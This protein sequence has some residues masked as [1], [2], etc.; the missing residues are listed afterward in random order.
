VSTAV[1]LYIHP[2]TAIATVAALAY[3]GQLGLRGR[4]VRRD[5]AEMLR[6]HAR[7]TPYVYA[8]VLLS[9]VLGGL[10]VWWGRSDLDFADSGHFRVGCYVVAVLSVAMVLSR[11]IDRVPNGRVI[12]PLLGA[13]A[14]L[15][16]AFQVF[17]G[18]QIMPK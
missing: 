1:W 4:Q 7:V 14:V 13:L 12:H 6:R 11:L 10:S 5:G 9:W 18:L 15:L 8:L 17:L 16:A 2:V 3:A